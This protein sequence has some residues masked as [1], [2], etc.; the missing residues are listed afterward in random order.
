MAVD[1]RRVDQLEAL[2][3]RM[4]GHRVQT[5]GGEAPV[6]EVIT[7]IDLSCRGNVNRRRG[8]ESPIGR[9]VG[10]EQHPSTGREAPPKR[11]EQAHRILNPVE[12]PE[13]EDE[14]E[15]LKGLSTSEELFAALA[16]SVNAS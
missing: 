2:E 5:C 1:H 12:N 15:R 7:G 6:H 16:E 8:F 13:A 9:A 11:L 3:A 14:V 10:F 4:A